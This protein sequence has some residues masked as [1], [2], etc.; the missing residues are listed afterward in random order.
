MQPVPGLNEVHIWRHD[1]GAAAQSG[2]VTD[3]HTLL[4]SDEH[5]RCL[6]LR[7]EQRRRQFVIGRALCRQVLSRYAPVPPQDWRF[8]LGRR[9]KPFIVTPDLSRPMWFSLSHADG[10][11]ICAVT[12]AGPEIGIDIERIVAGRNALEIA[13]QFFPDAEAAVLRKLPPA[14]RAETFVHLWALKESFVKAREIGLAE[15]LPGT[16]FDLRR[17]NEISV[18]FAHGMEEGAAHWQFRLLRLDQDRIIALAV[19]TP[20]SS[21]LKLRVQT[22]YPM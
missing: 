8:A 3:L 9:G 11:S 5:A 14:R 20:S 7:D 19:R 16:T 17:L 4:S 10:V 21:Q 1:H 18:T 6:H 12:G 15:G 22:W 2:K 13:E